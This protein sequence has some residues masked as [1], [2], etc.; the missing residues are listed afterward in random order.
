MT[1]V[2]REMTLV[3]ANEH[4]REAFRDFRPGADHCFATLWERSRRCSDCLPL[5]VFR[6]GEAHEGIRLKGRT[7][8]P[9]ETYRVLALPVR[10][11]DGEL[12]WVAESLLRLPFQ[13]S[14]SARDADMD[15]QLGEMTSSSGTAFVVI[16]RQERIVS[17]SPSATSIFGYKLEEILGRGLDLLVPRDRRE[18]LDRLL[19]GV[20]QGAEVQRVET[21]WRSKGGRSVPV[22][23]S[24][25]ALH[26]AS[27]QVVGCSTVIEDL[28]ELHRLQARIDAQEKLL[29]HVVRETAGAV[30]ATG[31]DGTVTSWNAQAEQLTGHSAQQA[32]GHPLGELVGSNAARNLFRALQAGATARDLR[33][34]WRDAAG[35]PLPVEI[36]A[37]QLHDASGQAMGMAAVVSDGRAKLTLERQMIRSEKLAAV[38]NLAAGLAHEI[39]TPLNIISATAEYLLLD[40]APDDAVRKELS[41]IVTETERIGGLVRELLTFARGSASERTLVSPRAAIERVLRLA[42]ISIERKGIVVEQRIPEGLRSVYSEPDALHQILLNLVLNAANAVGEGGRILLIAHEEKSGTPSVV[43]EVHDNGP[44]VPPAIRERIFDPFFTTRADGTGL[45]LAVCARIVES[46]GGDIRVGDSPLGGACFAV[47]LP[48]AQEDGQ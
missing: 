6:T 17:W 12:C 7:G 11:P 20:E 2:D 31:V 24:A 10:N 33:M 28:S 41:A 34:E 21:L 1:L 4:I 48:G 43:V 19:R 25:A 47:E 9:L 8:E 27:G 15:R 23:I 13:R 44:G 40:R 29:A 32:I 16:D 18:E 37:A 30:V 42:R 14:H 35:N 26:D 39:G 46:H 45:G 5:L 3:W 36:T 22:A 38:G